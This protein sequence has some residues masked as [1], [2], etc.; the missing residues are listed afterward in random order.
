M[1]VHSV[2]NSCSCLSFNAHH[3]RRFICAIALLANATIILTCS[4]YA[5]IIAGYHKS[6]LPTK[7]WAFNLIVIQVALVLLFFSKQCL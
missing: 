6:A 3:Q 2:L 7:L 4:H 5:F 1:K